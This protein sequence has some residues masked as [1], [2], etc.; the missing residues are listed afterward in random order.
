MTRLKCEYFGLSFN[1]FESITDAKNKIIK[2][3]NEWNFDAH[4]IKIN[5][6]LTFE[7]EVCDTISNEL[8]DQ[9]ILYF[10]D[11]LSVNAE[12]LE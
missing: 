5:D 12:A 7:I 8:L 4:V 11:Q 1:R 2:A 3:F 10:Y 6:D 9:I